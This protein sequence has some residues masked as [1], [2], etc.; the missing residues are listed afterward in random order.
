MSVARLQS[1]VKITAVDERLRD[2][3]LHRDDRDE[4]RGGR[5]G[6][7][8]PGGALELAQPERA[9]DRRRDERRRDEAQAGHG[10]H[11]GGDS[12]AT[13]PASWSPSARSI[14]GIIALPS[15]PTERETDSGSGMIPTRDEHRGRHHPQRRGAQHRADRGWPAAAHPARGRGDADDER[16]DQDRDVI[17]RRGGERAF[18]E[19]EL[20]QR[21]PEVPHV[22]EHR[23]HHVRRCDLRRPAQRAPPRS[24]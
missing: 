10:E 9:R 24:R 13:C 16:G 2:V 12:Q 14:A 21:Q 17:D 22:A 11:V 7:Q 3:V 20:H 15:R 18:A 5:T 6:L 23:Q 4:D 8:D 19:P 1:V